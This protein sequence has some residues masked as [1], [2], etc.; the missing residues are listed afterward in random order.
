MPTCRAACKRRGALVIPA[1]GPKLPA[2]L[3]EGTTLKLV[4][5]TG[6]GSTGST[7]PR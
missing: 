2:T 5:V 6:A 1:V 7:R 4:Q 3:F